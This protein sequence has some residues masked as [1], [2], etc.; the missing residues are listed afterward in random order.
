MGEELMVAGTEVV[1]TGLAIAVAHEAVLGT[2]AMT[3]ELHAT[4]A[5]L[6]GQLLALHS[7]KFVLLGRIHHFGDGAVAQVAEAV[8]GIDEVVA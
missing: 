3:G 1:E 4:L 8:L 6:A 2:L 5:T 7:G